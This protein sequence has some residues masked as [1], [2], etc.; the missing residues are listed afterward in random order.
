MILGHDI[1]TEGSTLDNFVR[2]KHSSWAHRYDRCFKVTITNVEVRT[3]IACF[4]K[5]ESAKTE[6]NQENACKWAGPVAE[7][8]VRN[9]DADRRRLNALRPRVPGDCPP[10]F[11]G[12]PF[13]HQPTFDEFQGEFNALMFGFQRVSKTGNE[14]RLF[15][16]LLPESPLDS[17]E[18]R[19]PSSK[20]PFERDKSISQRRDRAQTSHSVHIKCRQFKTLFLGCL[21]Q[22]TEP[23]LL[24]PTIIHR[25]HRQHLLKTRRLR[26]YLQPSIRPRLPSLQKRGNHQWSQSVPEK[27]RS[28]R[29]DPPAHSQ[30]EQALLQCP[31]QWSNSCIRYR[32][33]R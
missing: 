30:T 10:R 9:S 4:S 7:S 25:C 21:G 28:L 31:G 17:V 27:S 13:V 19:F 3:G 2:Q 18:F 22:C 11:V 5:S 29:S 8:S 1:R 24:L 26:R 15:I 6:S 20:Q 14:Q 16:Q 33:F 12:T 23:S 32:S